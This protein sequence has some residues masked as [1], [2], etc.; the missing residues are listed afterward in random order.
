MGHGIGQINRGFCSR[1]FSGTLGKA[2]CSLPQVYQQRAG[3]A[4]PR[5]ASALSSPI[6]TSPSQPQQPPS[7][8][9]DA[10]NLASNFPEALGW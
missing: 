7:P 10:D 5:V 9:T 8:L 1:I 4:A 3:P 2:F 6:I